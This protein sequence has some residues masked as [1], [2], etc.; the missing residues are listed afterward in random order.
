[1]ASIVKSLSSRLV[2]G[3]SQI[4][5]RVTINRTYRPCLKTGIFIQPEYFVDGEIRIRKIKQLA[6]EERLRV[7]AIIKRLKAYCDCLQMLIAKN[8]DNALNKEWLRSSMESIPLSTFD[9]NVLNIEKIVLPLKE[10]SGTRHVKRLYDYFEE[11]LQHKNVS[12]KRRTTYKTMTK[13][14]MRYELFERL[15]GNK[16]FSLE[17]DSLCSDVMRSFQNFCCHEHDLSISYPAIFRRINLEIKNDEDDNV[18]N[19]SSNY[20]INFMKNIKAVTNWLME[21]GLL[22]TNPFDNFEIGVQRYVAHPVFIT[23]EERKLLYQTDFSFNKSMETQ[24]DIFVFQ[25]MTGCRYGDMK[26]LT[27]DNILDGSYLQYVPSKT[28]HTKNPVIPKVPLTKDALAI[29]EKYKGVD[30]KGRLL[31]F[32]T[33]DFYNKKLKEIFKIAGLT[34]N[35]Q[36]LNKNTGVPEMVP[37]CDYVSSHLARRTFIGNLYNK[38]K[39]PSLISVM[40]GHVESSRAF[41]RYRDIGD[42]ARRDLIDSIV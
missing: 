21:K 31:P 22:V 19:T 10:E 14:L 39:D 6:T 27:E 8:P 20:S 23:I 24:R 13:H 3:K 4:L 42:D 5:V 25:C 41:S 11:Y 1:M 7:E 38:I 34:R 29:I 15:M 12:L 17:L 26:K 2:D 40:S 35:V 36:I 9:N 37:L 16:N 32:A 28:K 30:K 33:E 18:S